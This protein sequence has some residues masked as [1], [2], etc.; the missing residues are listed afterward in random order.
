MAAN[1]RRSLSGHSD[2]VWVLV[3]AVLCALF[4][5]GLLRHLSQRHEVYNLG[6]ELAEQTREHA[7]L[8]E[9]NRRL[10][11]EI[12]LQSNAER[13]E[14]EALRRLGLRATAPSQ[15]RQGLIE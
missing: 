14:Q 7:L 11:V 13:L 15:I 1:P 6:Y 9:E 5:G 8:L 3:S 10:R 2:L 4:V 12:A